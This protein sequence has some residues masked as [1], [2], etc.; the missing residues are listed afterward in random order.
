MKTGCSCLVI[1]K[2]NIEWIHSTEIKV[3]LEP[4]TGKAA[5]NN[6]SK[7][8]KNRPD[9]KLKPGLKKSKL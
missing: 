8:K 1:F 6:R 4:L 9:I 2:K 3:K 5:M 7:I